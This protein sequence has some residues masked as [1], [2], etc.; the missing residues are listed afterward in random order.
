MGEVE[1]PLTVTPTKRLKQTLARR[2]PVGKGNLDCLLEALQ[3]LLMVTSREDPFF[4]PHGLEL[5]QTHLKA[6]LAYLVTLEETILET[7]WWV[8]ELPGENAPPHVASICQWM[9]A[10]PFRT[11]VL[12][13][14]PNDIHWKDD[15]TLQA[16]GIRAMAGALLRCN[17]HAKG[18]VFLHYSEPHA[19]SRTELA[20]LD[21]VSGFLAHLLEMEDLKAALGRL[22]NALAITKAVVEDSSLE[23]LNTRLP[24]LRYLEIWLGAN[25]AMASS[26]PEV[27]TVAEWDMDMKAS[28]IQNRIRETAS[29][30]R[31]GDLF[32]SMGH[33][34]FL[35][36]LQRTAQ[37]MGDLFLRR[38]Q[39]VIGSAC[40][41]ATLWVPGVDD[42]RL[43]SVRKRL[44]QAL[45]SSKSLQEQGLVWKLSNVGSG[46][47][48]RVH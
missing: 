38:L 40:I 9:L 28:D 33:G 34:R 42:P 46:P 13:D 44:A 3:T 27:M 6:D 1:A 45:E 10:N 14:I 43:E 23:D 39:P 31:G 8:P 22:E 48:L 2:I 5:L 12:A 19:Y 32:V 47:D 24:N 29:R 18:F 11:L 37:S 16:R 7:Q 17:G 41:G 36:I 30:V 26:R 21:A 4:L 35:L 25:L 15:E 20:L